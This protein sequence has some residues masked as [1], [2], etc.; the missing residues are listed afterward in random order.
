VVCTSSLD[1]GVDF[2]PVERVVQIG[3]AKGIARLLQRAG[4]S[5]HRPGATASVLCVPTQWLEM[6][7]AAAVKRAVQ[8]GR[9]EARSPL[10]KPLDV[11]A[12]HMVSRGLGGGFE[13]GELYNEVRSA[14]SYR[15]LTREEFDWALELVQHGGATLRAYPSSKG[16]RGWW[17]SGG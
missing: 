5:G 16:R 1:L 12:Q 15:D 11:L 8:E 2:A 10:R 17:S 7:E 3:S 4:R 6:I 14:W 13:A 9:I